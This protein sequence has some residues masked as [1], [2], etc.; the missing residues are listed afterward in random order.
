VV[1][2]LH[3]AGEQI[4]TGVVG[5]DLGLDTL[6]HTSDGN[7]SQIRNGLETIREETIGDV[8]GQGDQRWHAAQGGGDLAATVEDLDGGDIFGRIVGALAH[9]GDILALLEHA[10]G[11]TESQIAD[12]IKGQ[13]VE[14]VQGIQASIAGLG[15]GL[16]I[17]ELVPLLDERLN[18]SV[19]ILFE[20]ANGLGA[21][22]V[23]DSLALASVL[24]TVTSVEQTAADGDKGIV[25]VTGW[26]RI[27]IV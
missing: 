3:Q 1:L 18:V 15:V 26:Q 24:G 22:G 5:H 25:E 4:D 7:T 16:Q 13:I 11:S 2:A 20:L 10:E 23:G 19:D 17:G 27:S 12:D 8:L 6:A 9:L 21:E 14:P